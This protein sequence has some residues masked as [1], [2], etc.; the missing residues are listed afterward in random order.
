[1]RDEKQRIDTLNVRA[2]PERIV[3]RNLTKKFAKDGKWFN[4]VTHLSFGVQAGECFGLLGLNGAGKTSTLQILTGDLDATS[5]E[6][7]LNGRFAKRGRCIDQVGYCP[8]SDYLPEFLTL[9]EALWLY[10]CLRGLERTCVVYIVDSIVENFKLDEFKNTLV[11]NL[12]FGPN[13]LIF[14]LK[15]KS[16]KFI[17]KF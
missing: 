1:V 11:Q 7:R 13:Y 10:A 14:L 5:G 9:R 2:M 3:A 4:A 15:R 6:A 12:R 17:F 16:N 8:Q